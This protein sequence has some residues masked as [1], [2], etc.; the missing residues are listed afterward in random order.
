[1]ANT[2]LVVKNESGFL[3]AAGF[4]MSEY[5][6][7]DLAGLELTFDRIRIP[8]GG[9]T[10][11][12]VPSTD[13]E[14][15][16]SVKEFSGVILHHHPVFSYYREKYTG[17]NNPPDCGSYDGMVGEG[18]PGGNCRACPLN[19]FGSDEGGGKACKNRRRIYILREGEVFPLILSL[20]TG[21]V[22]EFTK[23]IQRL[24][25]KGRKSGTVVTKFGLRKAM[26]NSG[27]AYSQAT[28]AVERVLSTEEI[29]AVAPLAEQVKA[30]SK[31]LVFALDERVETPFDADPVTGEIIE[32]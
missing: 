11:Y 22:K 30:I 20:P 8:S 10:L 12:E 1:M 15:T 27:I 24:L 5:M 4:N 3:Q 17:G 21:S 31:D 32:Q 6:S 7:D 2:D 13:A 25:S 29:A 9:G 23:Y 18:N 14:E 26:S 19:Q 16:D 28:F